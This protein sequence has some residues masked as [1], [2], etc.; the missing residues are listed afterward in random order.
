[1]TANSRHSR[2]HERQRQL[3]QAQKAAERLARGRQKR[4]GA[5]TIAE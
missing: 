5:A 1:M 4:R 3:L 2:D